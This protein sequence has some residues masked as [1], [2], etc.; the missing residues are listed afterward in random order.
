MESAKL[1]MEVLSTALN[2]APIPE[3]F[4]STVTVIPDLALQIIEI[5]EGVKGNVKDARALVIY[6]AD[7]TNMAMTPFKTKPPDSL[8]NSPE[9]NKRIGDFKKVLVK[10]QEEMEILMHR[11]LRKRIFSYVRDASKLADMKKRVDAAANQLQL[12][13]AIATGH[14][15]EFLSHEQHPA[16]LKQ[17]ASGA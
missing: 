16:R 4:K 2:V 11:K 1:G 9:T 14:G 6:V 7:M 12:Q 3:P 15:V 10:I 13:T 5:V 8:D 17:E